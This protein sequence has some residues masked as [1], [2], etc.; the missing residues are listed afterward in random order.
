MRANRRREA[1]STSKKHY[2]ITWQDGN[3]VTH[4]AQV[5]GVD[6]SVSGIGFR[7]RM[8]LRVGRGVYVQGPDGHP[9]GYGIVRHCFGR[10]GVFIVGLELDEETKKTSAAVNVDTQD[11]YAFLQV[12][13]TAEPETIHR[14]YRFWASRFH[15]DKADTGDPEKF[16]LLNRA[17]EI[18]SDPARRAE[19]D[20][21][22]GAQKEQPITVFEAGDFLD[23]IEG[24]RNRRLGVLSMLYNRRRT[25]S[26]HPQVSLTELEIRM[27]FP[28]EY[29]DFT[30]W[31]LKSKKLIVREE[32][33]DFNLTAEGVDYIEANYASTPMLQKLLA[34]GAPTVTGLRTRSGSG[35]AD[36]LFAHPDDGEPEAS[37]APV[38]REPY[39][40]QALMD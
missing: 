31:Y 4:A 40:G 34:A 3:G 36:R 32:N 17:Y 33:S 23:G 27:G 26:R 10:N 19:Y 29:L 5:R 20:Q 30:T 28:R 22:L 24:E 16:L 15:P 8:E 2:S 6:F 37:G 13:S 1:R 12:T 9:T 35:Y 14:V 25:N 18:L 7:C 11:F 38:P 39:E 21:A